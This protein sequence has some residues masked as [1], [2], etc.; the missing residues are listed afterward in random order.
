MPDNYSSS[1]IDDKD[2][3]YGKIVGQR[4]GS[5]FLKFDI[6][7]SGEKEIR[8]NSSMLILR[9]I[10]AILGW[11]KLM[12]ENGFM[13]FFPDLLQRQ[14]SAFKIQSAYRAHLRKMQLYK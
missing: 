8:D 4:H 9:I 10:R 7:L 6:N 3:L 12:P 13:F 14:V 2:F 5:D 11:N 1:K